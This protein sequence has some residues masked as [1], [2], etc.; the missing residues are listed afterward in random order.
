MM[1]KWID[2]VNKHFGF[3]LVLYTLTWL[4]IGI[5]LGLSIEG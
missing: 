2:S 3:W 1:K 4:G 5:F